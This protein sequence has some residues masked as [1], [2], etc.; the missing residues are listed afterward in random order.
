MVFG[1]LDRTKYIPE[2]CIIDK[3]GMWK[4]GNQSAIDITEALKKIKKFD[5]VFIAMHGA[6]G[7][8]GRLQAL[9]EWIDM[10]YSGSGVASSAMAMDKN[11]ANILYAAHGLR[12]PKYGIFDKDSMR[13]ALK[14]PLPF[15]A[16][17]INGGSSVGVSI[18]KKRN[19]FKIRG[20]VMAQEYI[21]GREFSCGVIEDTKGNPFALPPI[22]IIPKSSFFS[23]YKAK[24]EIGASSDVTPPHLPKRQMKEL[25]NLALAAHRILGCSGVS[26]SDFMMRDST[27]YILETNTIPGMTQ[28]S[29]LPRE[30]NA[31]GISFPKLLD[32]IIASGL[33]KI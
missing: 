15:V 4:I 29:L 24:Y 7:E 13:Q 32:M 14:F 9:L 12:V 3:W 22:E 5:F 21:K 17:P 25:Q 28:T 6:F 33:K 30:A 23:D 31:I 18:I 11:V 26:R 8:D 2:I 1:N 27:F 10:P 20:R 16:K 19:D